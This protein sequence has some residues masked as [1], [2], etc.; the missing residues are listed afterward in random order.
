MYDFVSFF[1]F[2]WEKIMGGSV[3]FVLSDVKKRIIIIKQKINRN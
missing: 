2:S 1:P 3:R